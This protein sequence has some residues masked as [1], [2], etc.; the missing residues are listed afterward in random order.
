M[1]K[2]FIEHIQ[3]T[4]QPL[5]ATIKG[6]DYVIC[7]D[8]TVTEIIPESAHPGTLDLSS[9]DA[10][11]KL[12]HTEAVNEAKSE[13]FVTI[14][15]HTTVR[16]FGR[17]DYTQRG[18]RHTFYEVKATDVPG[19]NDTVKMGFEEMQIALRTRFQ[20]TPDTQYVQRLLSEIST[21]AKVTFN[22]NGVAT[23]IV[24]SKG[25][26]MQG[27]ETIR[28]IVT[29]RPYRTFQEVEQPESTFL[30]R[31][32]ERGITFTEA[33]GGMWKLKARET[34]KAY[35]EDALKDLKGV[36]VAL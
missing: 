28:P 15:S 1:M 17:P 25:I 2:E 3:N 36:I 22:D 29:L 23:T 31:V 20:E 30:I 13:I 27:N 19:W 9:L 4:T 35:L 18:Y 21:G 16:C 14:P 26:A 11:V 8:G 6:S 12:I 7:H 33:D 34:V 24:T 5:H 32:S 10:L